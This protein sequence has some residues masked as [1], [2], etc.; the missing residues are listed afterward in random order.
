MQWRRRRRVLVV[1]GS[2]RRA[3]LIKGLQLLSDED[4][5]RL[6][7]ARRRWLDS[8]KVRAVRELIQRFQDAEETGDTAGGVG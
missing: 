8:P 4:D 7:C 1:L 3:L 5:E 6:Q 2:S